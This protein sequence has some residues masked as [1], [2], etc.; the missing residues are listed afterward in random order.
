MFLNNTAILFLIIKKTLV[1]N[2][3]KKIRIKTKVLS[4]R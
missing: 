1:L 3:K 4:L 2:L